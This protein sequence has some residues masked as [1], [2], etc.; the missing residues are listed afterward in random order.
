MPVGLKRLKS[1]E[2]TRSNG[3]KRILFN[4]PKITEIKG[5]VLLKNPSSREDIVTTLTDLIIGDTPIVAEV[6]TTPAIVIDSPTAAETT[7]HTPPILEIK[8]ITTTKITVTTV[9]TDTKGHITTEDITENEL[10]VQRCYLTVESHPS[11]VSN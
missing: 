1:S 5:I 3:M 7:D 4:L 10:L 8:D 9:L 11:E 6:A 2:R